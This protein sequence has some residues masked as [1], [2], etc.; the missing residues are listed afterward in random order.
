MPTATK[1]PYEILIRYREGKLFAAHVGWSTLVTEDDGAKREL[2]QTLQPFN[3]GNNDGFP[4]SDI[5]SQL[6]IDALA[7]T[8]EDAVTIRA[9]EISAKKAAQ[10][11]AALK[12]EITKLSSSKQESKVEAG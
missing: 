12:K 6:Q 3:L 10:E 8:A 4:L 11:I 7:K 1:V 9:H 2:P 5:F